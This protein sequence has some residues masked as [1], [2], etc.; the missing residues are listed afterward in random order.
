MSID[1][2]IIKIKMARMKPE[3][4]YLYKIFSS[5][6]KFIPRK[7]PYTSVYPNYIYFTK[8][9]KIYIFYNVSDNKLKYDFDICDYLIEN[10][11]I[12]LFEINNTVYNIIKKY[13]FFNDTIDIDN[14][15]INN[16]DIDHSSLDD[17]SKKDL[18]EGL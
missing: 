14:L 7:Q 1:S 12:N 10:Y 15:D 9:Q 8:G 4:R 16:F 6:K 13:N 3:E 17:C 11:N 5:L 18:G 2:D